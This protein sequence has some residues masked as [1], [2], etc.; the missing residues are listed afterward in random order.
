MVMCFPL[1]RFGVFILKLHSFVLCWESKSVG[2]FFCSR[3]TRSK[4]TAHIAGHRPWRFARTACFLQAFFTLGLEVTCCDKPLIELNGSE[5]N[6]TTISG[7]K[8]KRSQDGC[9]AVEL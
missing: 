8:I 5:L 2:F 4:L 9:D 6:H 3:V 1:N 7:L